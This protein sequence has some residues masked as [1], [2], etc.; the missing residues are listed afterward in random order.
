MEI[1]WNFKVVLEENTTQKLA[2][3]HSKETHHE[4]AT[5]TDKLYILL[6]RKDMQWNYV[7]SV[8]LKITKIGRFLHKRNKGHKMLI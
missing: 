1:I 3:S 7:I 5:C 2:T 4:T 6:A 8:L